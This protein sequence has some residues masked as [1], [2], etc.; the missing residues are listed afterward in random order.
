[1]GFDIDMAQLLA[2][3]MK[4]N[5]QFIP[6]EQDDLVAQLDA[7]LFDVGMAGVPVT[8]PG[9]KRLSFQSLILRPRY[10]LLFLIIGAMNFP[11]PNP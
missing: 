5:L 4:V 10:A 7:G 9:W 8:P 6:F 1:M 11:L 2:R 3:E